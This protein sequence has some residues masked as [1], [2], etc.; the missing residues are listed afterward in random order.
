MFDIDFTDDGRFAVL[1]Q[2]SAAHKVLVFL[3]DKQMLNR[4]IDGGD[5]DK[6]T[7]VETALVCQKVS[8]ANDISLALLSDTNLVRSSMVYNKTWTASYFVMSITEQGLAVI[9]ELKKESYVE[10]KF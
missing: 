8:N 2:D 6:I 1:E 9:D 3:R 5:K 10:I 7:P 4:L